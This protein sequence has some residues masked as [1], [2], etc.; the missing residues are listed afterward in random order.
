M[1]VLLR[2]CLM[3]TTLAVVS[4]CGSAAQAAEAQTV[5]VFKDAQGFKLQVDGRDM[6]VLG[7]NWGYMP[8]GENYTYDFWGKSDAF[9]QDALKSEMTL[10]K[11]MG[12]NTIR[13]SVGIP[14]RWITYIYKKY[15][16][17]GAQSP[18]GALRSLDRRGLAEPDQLRR[19]ACA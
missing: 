15:G 19:Q 1:K 17:Y 13:Q 12:V 4:L 9:I 18:R 3:L 11:E 6:M 5:T 8:I 16:I 7:M 2:R 14:P 10:L